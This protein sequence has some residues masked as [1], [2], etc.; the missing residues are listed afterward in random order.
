M[1]E[2]VF[3]RSNTSD[4]DDDD[5]GDL[6]LKDMIHAN[7]R[8]AR[9]K[10]EFLGPCAQLKGMFL[11]GNQSFMDAEEGSNTEVLEGAIGFAA[12]MGTLIWEQVEDQ[13]T[14]VC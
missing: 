8:V 9:K 3:I 5:F 10:L 6:F 11:R 2:D 13:Q 4:A 1:A 14:H 7:K 12:T